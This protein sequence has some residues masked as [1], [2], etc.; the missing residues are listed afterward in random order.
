MRLVTNDSQSRGLVSVKTSSPPDNPHPVHFDP[1]AL[2]PAPPIYSPSSASTEVTWNPPSID[3]PLIYP[4]FLLYPSHSQSDFI[5]HFSEETSLSDHINVMFPSSAS[6]G[7]SFPEWD[8]KQ[9]YTAENLVVYVETAH[10]RLLKAGRD[11]TLRE[12][13]KKAV[14]EPASGKGT[15]DGMVLRDGLLSFIVLVKG[16]REQKWIDEYKKARDGK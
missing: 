3:T 10:R 11:L 7:P 1:D 2:P 4:V 9:E 8:E 13:I 14:K 6:S 15:S 5:T 16:E 12:V